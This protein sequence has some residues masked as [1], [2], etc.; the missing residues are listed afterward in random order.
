VKLNNEF[1]EYYEFLW[2][3]QKLSK[4]VINLFEFLIKQLYLI[5]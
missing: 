2:I 4:G 5:W 1:K 3:N